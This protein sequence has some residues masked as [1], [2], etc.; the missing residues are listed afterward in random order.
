MHK[1]K[2]MFEFLKNHPFA[3]EAFFE[4]SFVLTFAFPKEILQQLTLIF[5]DLTALKRTNRSNV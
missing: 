5:F 1:K 4:S 3:V 2:D